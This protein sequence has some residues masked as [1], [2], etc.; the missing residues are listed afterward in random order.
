MAE[1]A[2][3]LPAGP[4]YV[5]ARA[6]EAEAFL[7]GPIPWPWVIA[8]GSLPGSALHVGLAIWFRAGRAKSRTVSV[9]L[10]AV[11]HAFGF[12]RT[13]A[14]RALGALAEAGLVCV[15]RAPGQKPIVTILEAPASGPG[16]TPSNGE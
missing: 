14:S 9:S 3:R 8:A 2:I 16:R 11:A 12:H 4:A 15:K 6:R 7:K 1:R 5:R 13:R 10:T